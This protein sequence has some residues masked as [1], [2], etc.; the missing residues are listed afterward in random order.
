MHDLHGLCRAGCQQVDDVL[1]LSLLVH[2]CRTGPLQRMVPH[3]ALTDEV[4]GGETE[5]CPGL[6]HES[7]KIQN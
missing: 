1:P 6:L 5:T 7:F 4:P 3:S 2:Q